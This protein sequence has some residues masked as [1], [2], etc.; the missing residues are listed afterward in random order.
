MC[1]LLG[2]Q[3]ARYLTMR[4]SASQRLFTAKKE[5]IL[6]AGSVGSPFILM[7]S[8]IGD[9]DDLSRF[10]IKPIVNLPSVGRNLSDHPLTPIVWP[11]NTTETIETLARDPV[12]AAEVL[13][14]WRTNRTGPLVDTVFNQIGWLRVKN[15]EKIFQKYGDPSAGPL[16]PHFGLLFQV[17]SLFSPQLPTC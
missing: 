7:H 14:E 8:G 17:F 2:H 3:G 13:A 10:G 6:S 1:S 15:G 5:V 4:L 12:I 9:A 11:V 16:A